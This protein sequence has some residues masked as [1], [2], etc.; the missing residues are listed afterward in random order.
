MAASIDTNVSVI[1]PLGPGGSAQWLR[2]ALHCVQRQTL[3]TLDIVVVINGCSASAVDVARSLALEDDRMRVLTRDEPSLPAALNGGIAAARFDL[4][5]RMDADDLC[6]PDRLAKQAS[7]LVKN[8]NVAGVGTAFD[9]IDEAGATRQ[10]VQPPTEPARIRWRL[11]LGNVFAHGSM[12]L[13]KSAVLAAG[14][15]DE[16]LFRGQDYDLWL[17]MI[18]RGFAL[19]NLPDVLYQRR[20]NA[21][22][23]HAGADEAQRSVAAARMVDAWLASPMGGPNRG[24][25]TAAVADALAGDGRAA[26]NQI[27]AQLDV[28]GP[29]MLGLL[30]RCWARDRASAH[31]DERAWRV[32]QLARL[33]EVAR[34]IKRAGAARVWLW[35]AG[36]HTHWLAPALGQTDLHVAGVVDD[37]LAGATRFGFVVQAPEAIPAGEHALISTDAQEASIAASAGAQRLRKRNVRVWRLYDDPPESMS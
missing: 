4:I 19:A 14:G 28:N 27:E 3:T 15:Y 5:A 10:T 23:P 16:S 9:I 11:T 30:A 37:A 8:P 21:D 22:D 29:A 18:A 20:V 32:C 13:R 1:L 17:R 12:L 7:Y 2:E 35:G 31:V 24:A 33:R 26:A 6:S 36:E 25:L 34:K